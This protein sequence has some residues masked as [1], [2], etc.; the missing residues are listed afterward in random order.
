MITQDNFFES[1]KAIFKGCKR[2]SRKPDYVSRDRWG[3]V[4]SEYWYFED[5]V[6]RASD[7]WS[8]YKSLNDGI[9]RK[10]FY[11]NEYDNAPTHGY[12]WQSAY[13]KAQNANSSSNHHF[14]G[15]NWIASC[16]WNLKT[17]SKKLEKIFAND[18]QILAGFAK[19]TDFKIM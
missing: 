16:K 8:T 4:S 3:Y 5:G 15:C 13:Y 1:T 9:N 2:P 14:R 12:G 6:I 18:S 11:Q 7:H 10:S 19:W 17:N